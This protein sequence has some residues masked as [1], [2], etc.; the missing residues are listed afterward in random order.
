MCKT[1]AKQTGIPVKNYPQFLSNHPKGEDLFE[2]KSQE[3]LADAIAM[4]ITEIDK[5][6]KPV[7]SRLIGVEG[8][9]GSGKSNVIEILEDKLK[10]NYTFFCFDSWGN[11]E[12][13]QRRSILELLTRKLIDDNKLSGM[14]KMRVFKQENG[15]IDNDDCTWSQKLESLL[16]RKSYSREVSVPSFNGWAKTFVLML[17]I[18]GLLIPLLDLITNEDFYWLAKLSLAIGPILVFLI[19]AWIKRKLPLM[20]KMYNTEG[21]SDTTS[22]VISEQEPSVREFKDW[23]KELS[24]GIPVE[25]K[26]VLVFDNMDRLPS[27]KVHQF[28][29]LIQTFFADDGYK[30]IWC[31]VPYDEDH[32]ASVFSNESNNDERIGLLRCFLNKTFPVIYRV[33]E[34]IVADYKNI[35]DTLFLQ[36]FGPTVDN[37]NA[38]IISQCYR[39]AN[40]N[41]NVRE[42]ITFINNNVLLAKQWKDK[43]SP[44]SRAIYLLK[45]D[46]M[47]HH[48]QVTN[49]DENGNN[50]VSTDEYILADEYYNDFSHI[51]IDKINLSTMRCEMAAMVYGVDPDNAAQIVVK[52]FI[53]NSIVSSGNDY[54]LAKY[55]NNHYFMFLL[56]DYVN[57][58]DESYYVRAASLINEID[59][60]NFQPTDKKRLDQIWRLFAKRFIV[61]VLSVNEYSDYHHIVF[62][63]VSTT[64]AKCCV[65]AFCK[66]IINNNKVSGDELYDQ[67]VAVFNEEYAKSFDI[68]TTCPPSTI[69]AKRFADYVKR[70]GAN[71]RQ[72]PLKTEADK[73]NEVLKQSINDVFPYNDVLNLLKEDNN[74]NVSE[75]GSYAVQQLNQQQK[76]LITAN[77]IAI[78]RIFYPTF[79]NVLDSNYI[80]ILWLEV[81]SADAKEAYDEIFTLKSVGALEQLPDDEN[82]IDILMNKILF[83]CTTT[84]LFQRYFANVN[85]G[86]RRNLI[87]KMLEEKRHDGRPNYPEFIEQWQK[88][89][90]NLGASREDIVRFAD[91][92]GYKS[93]SDQAQTKS[94]FALLSDVSWI[95]VLL[96]EIKPISK[97]LLQKCADEI[98][99]Q[100]T[101]QFVNPNTVTHT[102][103]NWDKALQKLMDTPYI[104]TNNLGRLTNLVSQ[105]LDFIA[106]K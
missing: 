58:L 56:L 20:W 104:Q 2:G 9:W 75:V 61:S 105:L 4:H 46:V 95:D 53:H 40:P 6:E 43:I 65:E 71:Y 82:H 59:D 16:S 49:I 69:D 14:T 22:Y 37:D 103:T 47:L 72:F 89:V 97:E 27:D 39:F 48:P 5:E 34:P 88:L 63:H 54:S 10:N 26:L 70:A 85:I 106:K 94:Y 41:P 101:T 73:L 83:Y 90:N 35:F 29:S 45:S 91:S 18:T 7:I 1:Q 55:S 77:I 13:L 17:L 28:W 36:A 86:F 24:I 19:V 30:N 33:P 74:Y 44:I 23:M 84:E 11:Q 100:D 98:I 42:I 92:W 15:I 79:Q 102:N 50:N 81:Q 25:E 87:K 62:S 57:S 76:A 52:R 66:K 67:L 32:L 96:K 99:N 64:L 31:I 68:L 38:E 80:N 12:D 21:R 3:R 78:Q 8:K 93:L 51:L 60:K